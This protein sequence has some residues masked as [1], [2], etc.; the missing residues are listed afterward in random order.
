[1]TSLRTLSVFTDREG[2]LWVGTASGIDRLRDQPV[3]MVEPLTDRGLAHVLPH[4]D[5]RIVVLETQRLNGI[6]LLWEMVAGKLVSRD[7]FLDAHVMARAPD[8]SLILAGSRG[9]ERQYAGNVRRIPMP[10]IPILSKKAIRFTD[11][12]A[13]NDEIWVRISGHGT[14]R[15]HRGEWSQFKSR[16]AYRFYVAVDRTG[17]AYI[18][19]GSRLSVSVGDEIQQ[20]HT[21]NSGVGTIQ[22]ICAAEEVLV[23]GTHGIGVVKNKRL[24]RI[25]FSTSKEITKINGFAKGSDGMY[26]LNS[27]QGL[28]RV[29]AEDWERSMRD[30]GISLRAEL[31]D[32]LDGYV[33]GGPSLWLN[34]TVFLGNDGKLWLAG[35]RGPAWIEPRAL[36]TNPITANVEILGLTSK[37]RQ[38]LPSSKIKLGDGAQNLQITYSSPSLRIPQRI[39]FRYRLVGADTQWIDAGTRRT[40]FYQNLVP[41]QY[42]FKVMA[43][44]ESGVRSPQVDSLT[45]QVTPHLTQTWWFYGFC[46]VLATVLLLIAY[47]MRVNRLAAR[48]E[49]R[50]EI[51]ASERESVARV[52]HDTFLQSLQGLFISMQAV[53]SELPPRSRARVEFDS[54]LERARHVLAEGRDEVKGLRSEFGSSKEFWEVLQRDVS[55][56]FPCGCTRLELTGPKGIDT[57]QPRIHHNVYA[58]VREAVVN[59]LRHT[60]SVVLIHASSEPEAFVLSVTD[61]GPGLRQFKTGKPGHFGVHS[62]REHAAQIGG[63]LDIDDV[64]TGGTRVTL[65]VPARLAYFN[66]HKTSK[67][68]KKGLRWRTRRVGIP[69]WA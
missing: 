52:L 15:F 20:I 32:A 61:Y 18:A 34:D 41:G 63:R 22:E 14:W 29:S 40:A 59:A 42:T 6:N 23:S 68:A 51:R 69:P 25:R 58:V 62:M 9:I 64:A 66:Q 36:R 7:N 17:S 11:L 57:L 24:H 2:N 5:G 54:L 19:G 26:W 16:E 10:P 55:M 60:E 28:L 48:L 35:E 3:H 56:I 44:N 27:P 1:M 67:P 37:G 46:I 47:R 39:R 50:F 33:G 31:L 38:Y 65:T 13:G 53:M 49:E 8:G 43:L 12:A 45:F 21:D 4:P 30:P